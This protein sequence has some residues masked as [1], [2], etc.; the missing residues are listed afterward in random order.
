MGVTGVGKSTLG[1]ALAAA[2]GVPFREG[3]SF[4][5]PENLCKM[6]AGMALQDADRWPWLNLLGLAIVARRQLMGAVAACSALKRSYR[7]RLRAVIGEPLLFV[8]LQAW[9]GHYMPAT[10]LDSQFATLELP[11]ADERA[12]VLPADGSIHAIIERLRA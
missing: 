8:F 2:L 6:R 5:P 1:A 7:D 10:L 12:I 4:H 11:G 3:D 9:Q